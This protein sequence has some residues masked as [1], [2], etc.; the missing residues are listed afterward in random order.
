MPREQRVHPNAF[1]A[2]PYWRDSYHF[3]QWS[4]ADATLMSFATAPP[5]KRP[6]QYAMRSSIQDQMSMTIPTLVIAW[7]IRFSLAF[8]FSAR[9]VHLQ[10]AGV[11]PALPVGLEPW[12]TRFTFRW[13]S[14]AADWWKK[15]SSCA[16]GNFPSQ[17]GTLTS[18]QRPRLATFEAQLYG[19][20][21]VNLLSLSKIPKA[22]WYALSFCRF[23]PSSTGF[24]Y[25]SRWA[26][27]SFSTFQSNQRQCRRL[28]SLLSSSCGLQ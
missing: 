10:F 8:L 18:S 5:R 16:L 14:L 9:L 7:F 1:R 26:S 6:A 4:Q 22:Q 3:R 17:F 28:A 23:P 15:C 13:S 20:A 12:F 27:P 24:R 19:L 25:F 21:K 2:A 11:F